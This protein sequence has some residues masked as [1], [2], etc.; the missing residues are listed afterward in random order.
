MS[1]CILPSQTTIWLLVGFGIAAGL[2]SSFPRDARAQPGGGRGDSQTRTTPLPRVETTGAVPSDAVVIFDGKS[3][4]NVVGPDGAPCRWPVEDG[5]LV[6]ETSGRERQGGLWTKLHFKDAQVHAEVFVPVTGRRGQDAGNSGLYLHGLFEMQ[7]LDSYENR[8]NPIHG[9]G[10]VYNMNP[11]LVN[12]ARPANNWQ[13]YDIIYRAPKRDENGEPK[14]AGS[15]TT[16]LNGVLV[17]DH[18]PV[19]RHVSV[20]APLYAQRTDYSRAIR[21]SVLQTGAGPLQLQDHDSPVRFRNVWIRPLDA[22]SFV[23]ELKDGP[24]NDQK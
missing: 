11:P 2:G 18:F 9:I 19:L 24:H 15:I 10:A 12:A 7:I 21:D 23:F 1:R 16:L 14:E 20:Y 13:V 8:V 6:C 22:N 5:A 17:Q 4:D 3:T